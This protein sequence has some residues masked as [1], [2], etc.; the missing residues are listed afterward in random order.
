LLLR[1][2]L[3]AAEIFWAPNLS[4]VSVPPADPLDGLLSRS[5]PSLPTRRSPNQQ[6]APFHRVRR[7]AV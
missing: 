4:S 2:T 1:T 7:G 6:C 3:E 5:V